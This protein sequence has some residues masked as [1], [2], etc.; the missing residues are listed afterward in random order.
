VPPTHAT[1]PF[2]SISRLPQLDRQLQG[3]REREQI[4]AKSR[5][6]RTESM[7]SSSGLVDWRGRPVNTKKHGGV[8]ASIF[9]H[10]K[11]HKHT[12]SMMPSSRFLLCFISLTPMA[13]AQL[14]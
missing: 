9:I 12:G 13:F 7:G 14:N 10:G 4:R 2:I 11:E 6:E 8:R 5:E 3:E 1:T